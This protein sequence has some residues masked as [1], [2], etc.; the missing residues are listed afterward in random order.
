[1]RQVPGRLWAAAAAVF[2]TA[3]GKRRRMITIIRGLF[4]DESG[5]E[6]VEWGVLAALIVGAVITA[7]T[8]LG[9]NVKRQFDTLVNATK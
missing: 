3:L 4:A 6:T 8:T 9:T 2:P 5:M 7:L 1:V